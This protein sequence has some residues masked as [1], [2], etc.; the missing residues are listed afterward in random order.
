MTGIFTALLEGENLSQL[1]QFSRDGDPKRLGT[2]GRNLTLIAMNERARARREQNAIEM[3]EVQRQSLLDAEIEDESV[4]IAREND[5]DSALNLRPK[6]SVA[7]GQAP[8]HMNDSD[9][10][11]KSF[12]N[13]FW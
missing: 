7:V 6:T 4:E 8:Q 12:R 11:V 5:R 1:D 13:S 3:A 10:G 2:V 9:E